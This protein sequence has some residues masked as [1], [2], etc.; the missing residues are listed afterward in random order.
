MLPKKDEGGFICSADFHCNAW[1]EGGESV[2]GVNG[3]I[4][5]FLVAIDFLFGYAR[6]HYVERIFQLGD[7][8]HLKKNIPLDA[9]NLLWDK[10]R[11]HAEDL[12]IDFVVGNHDR[13]DDREEVVTILPYRAF[14]GVYTEPHVDDQERIVYVPWLYDQSRVRAFL[15]DLPKKNYWMLLFHGEL[16][17]AVVGPTD[18][19]LKSKMTEDVIQT[20]R[21]EQVFA[22]HLHKRQNIKGVWYPGS[23]IPK[24]FGELET[25]KGFLHVLPS[26][27]VKVVQVPS[28]SFLVYSLGRTP[29]ERIIQK[30]VKEIPGNLVRIV[31]NEPLD[32]GILKIL[33]AAGPR[34]LNLRLARVEREVPVAPQ[35]QSKSF[36][37]LVGKYVKERGV[38]EDRADSYREYGISTLRRAE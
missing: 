1:L 35:P 3:R 24:D 23:L 29:S 33:E 38:P 2:N 31:T 32:P 21:F 4:R 15:K 26:G 36:D 14:A 34:Y 8:Y 25:D 16:D 12:T 13:E 7:V 6:A 27:E 18:Y 5:D 20:K 30:L 10:V 17:G 19:M 11:E 22:G 9:Y 28:P 37:D